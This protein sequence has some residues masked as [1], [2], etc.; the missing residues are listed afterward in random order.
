M[1]TPNSIPESVASQHRGRATR[2]DRG[3]GSFWLIALCCVAIAA[4]PALLIR[5]RDVEAAAL[6]APA[7]PTIA[8]VSMR[9]VQFYPATLEVIKGGAV[10]WKNDDLVPHTAT[11][12]SFDSGSLAS[13]QSWRR[14]FSEA[15]NF[16]Y[17]C[18]FHPH[19]KGVVIVR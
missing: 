8:Q 10:E 14:T 19:M 18:T 12:P 4:I 5:S 7:A 15:G 16:P 11:S 17:V 2:A 6:S 3:H 13:G 1:K 9:N